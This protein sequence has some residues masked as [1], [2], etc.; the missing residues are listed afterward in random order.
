M[1]GLVALWSHALAAAALRRAGCLRS[2]AAGT[3]TRAAGR[4]SPP[5]PRRRSGRSSLA[6]LGAATSIVSQLAESGRNL[7]FLAFMY[8]LLAEA[9]DAQAASAR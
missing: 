1:I 3:A 7:A 4:C 8:G 2:C 6:L 9:G 5:S